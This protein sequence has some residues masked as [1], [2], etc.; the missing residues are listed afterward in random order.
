MIGHGL[1]V[2]LK[3]PAR[4]LSRDRASKT[5]RFCDHNNRP[6]WRLKLRRP[7]CCSRLGLFQLRDSTFASPVDGSHFMLA[8]AN[9]PACQVAWLILLP[10]GG[11]V[12]RLLSIH[13]TAS[14]ARFPSLRSSAFG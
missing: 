1:A 12:R 2:P 4:T 10:V 5:R 7:R 13:F 14:A 6:D 8:P 9:K 11:D 3:G